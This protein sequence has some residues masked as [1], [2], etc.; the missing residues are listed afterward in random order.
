M[1]T[2]LL[3][4]QYNNTPAT[5]CFGP[6]FPIITEHKIVQKNC[7]KFPS[8][9]E[10]FLADVLYKFVLPDDGPVLPENS[11]SWCVVIPRI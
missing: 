9:S 2:V 7:F 10:R 11:R 8:C 4:P 5:T 3:K 1:H 6:K